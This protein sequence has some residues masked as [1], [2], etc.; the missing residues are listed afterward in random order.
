MLSLYS[1]QKSQWFNNKIKNS[2]P[3]PSNPPYSSLKTFSLPLKKTTHTKIKKKDKE[4]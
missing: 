1:N 4:T 3:S 2:T